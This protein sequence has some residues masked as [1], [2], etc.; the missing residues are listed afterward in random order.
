VQATA[1][2][3]GYGCVMGS[4]NLKAIAV[5]GTRGLKI[6]DGEAFKELWNE[7]YEWYTKGRCWTCAKALHRDSQSRHMQIYYPYSN[8]FPWGYYD[9]WEIPQKEKIYQ[10]DDFQKKHSVGNLGCAFCFVTVRSKLFQCRDGEW[11][12]E[13]RCL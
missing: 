6:Q 13:L 1:S 3:G 4:K 2:K 8:T 5:R 10:I 9:T 12:R 7:D 11:W